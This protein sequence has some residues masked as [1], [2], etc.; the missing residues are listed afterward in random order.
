MNTNRRVRC[1]RIDGK[2]MY[3]AAVS[4]L[5][6]KAVALYSATKTIKMHKTS[7]AADYVEGHFKKRVG[8]QAKAWRTTYEEAD[9]F[10]LF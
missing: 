5:I 8:E 2:S 6:S 10:F 7:K 1:L 4:R 3:K 9:N